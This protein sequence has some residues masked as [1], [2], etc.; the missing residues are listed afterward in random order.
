MR[1][2][3]AL[4]SLLSILS[5][6]VALVAVPGGATAAP[7]T[8]AAS[9]R[10][11]AVTSSSL[12]KSSPT[13]T[14][15][16]A[17]GCASA[18]CALLTGPFPAPST[19]GLTA[20]SPAV[21]AG[22]AA[23][24]NLAAAAATSDAHHLVP[25]A[26]A[27]SASASA[28]VSTGAKASAKAGADPI[29]PAPTVSCQPLGPGCDNVSS[30]AGGAV[31][32]KGLNAVD[33]GTLPTNPQGDIEPPDQGLCAGNGYRRRDEQHRRDHGLQ[34][35]P[36]PAVVAIPL[37]TVMG[38]TGRGWSSGG[39]PSCVFDHDNGG[40][41]FFTEIVSASTEASGGP[42]SGCFAGMANGCYEAIAVTVGSNPF[43]PYNVYFAQ[44]QLQPGRA[45]LPLPAQRLREDRDLARRV[46][47]DVRRVPAPACDAAGSGRRRL[48]R[49]AGVR[50][51]Q[52]RDGKGPAGHRARR[53]AR[54]GTSTSPSR[55]WACCRRQTGPAPPITRTI[56][57][58]SRA[59]FQV[60]PAQ[61]P[62]SCQFDNSH[63]GSAFMLAS[64][65]FTGLP[66]PAAAGHNRLAVFDWTGLRGLNSYNCSPAA[67]S[68]SAA[69]YS[70]TCC[71]TTT[72]RP[73][74]GP[75]PQK[76]GPIPLGDECGAAGLSTAQPAAGDLPRG[77]DRH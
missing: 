5:L 53:K 29:S 35:A 32:V 27:R 73:A 9:A 39:D 72:D 61:P 23:A 58:A 46:P 56:S 77:H 15:P 55:T 40:H 16:A 67:A 33:S 75:R 60:I 3:V 69:S 59:G 8:K 13:F 70:P 45:G 44:R 21:A 31:G 43:G 50:V 28:S 2:R 47:D 49:S 52:E 6:A 11:S 12:G 38:L 42:F 76:A 25:S 63:G 62:D 1:G 48:Q 34:P 36:A 22:A 51:R 14:G 68:S 64:P 10:T 57:P 66:T 30:S 41:W 20:S 37:D 74:R 4:L 17:T 18:G 71:P 24:K 26:L 54:T 7:V 65:D 19:A